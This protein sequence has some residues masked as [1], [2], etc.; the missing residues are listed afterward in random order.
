MRHE[1]HIRQRSENSFEIRYNLG[2]DPVT[3]KW[4]YKS[5]T[6]RGTRK[7]AHGEL[8]RILKALNTADYIE[9]TKLTTGQYLNEWIITIR[10]QVAPSQQPLI[11]IPMLRTPCRMM[12]P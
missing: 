7:E 1:G 9:P 6:F 10:S 2:K 3:G 8:Q 12:L 5:V 11:S 4:K